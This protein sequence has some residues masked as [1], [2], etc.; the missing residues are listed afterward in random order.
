MQALQSLNFTAQTKSEA[1]ANMRLFEPRPQSKQ[2][3][4]SAAVAL[5]I[6]SDASEAAVIITKRVS[7]LRSHGGQW[8][9]PGGRIDPGESPTQAA[10]RELHE[11]VDLSLDHSNVL[12][13]LDD[14][15][16]RSGYLVTPVVIWAEVSLSELKPNPGEVD[17]IHSFTF[18]ELARVD[19]PHLESIAQSDRQVLSMHY[20]DERIFAPTAALLYQFREVVIF[21]RATRVL[22]FDQPVF[23]WQ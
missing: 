23:A 8:A 2:E 3:L 22:H 7:T 17:S 20:G 11:E 4:R 5:T 19:S 18:S 21:G 1:R 9:L 16:T 6:F 14:Y 12:G 15:H 10:L 13:T